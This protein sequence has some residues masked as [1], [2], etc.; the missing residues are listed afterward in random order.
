[1]QNRILS[2]LPSYLVA[3]VHRRID[4]GRRTLISGVISPSIRHAGDGLAPYSAGMGPARA[5]RPAIQISSPAWLGGAGQ[6][7]P[8]RLW[9]RSRERRA[10]RRTDL[11]FPGPVSSRADFRAALARYAA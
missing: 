9:D 3:H 11:R 6:G 8:R 4:L 7:P 5:S 1:M 2:R 10:R